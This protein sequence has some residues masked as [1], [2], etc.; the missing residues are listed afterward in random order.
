MLT[1]PECRCAVCPDTAKRIRLTDS[2]GLYLEVSHTSK[3]WFWKFYPNGKESRLALGAYPAVGLK[4]A[5]LERDAARLKWRTEFINP[6]LERRAKRLAGKISSQNTFEEVARE[7]H[8]MRRV[9]W[10]ATY[11]ARWI[12]RMERDMF[13]WIGRM[14]LDFITAPVLLGALNKV[15]KRG[16]IETAHSL[17]Q[18]CGQ[19]FRYGVATGRCQ[20]N[21][22]ADLVD[23]LPPLYVKSVSAI[24]QPEAAGQL[25]CDID[26]YPGQ[27]TTRVCMQ[28]SALLWQRPGN[29]R[30]MRWED[31]NLAEAIWA[32][33]S[34]DMKRT[35]A[36]KLRG[37][38]HYV[39]LPRQ[40]IALLEEV[41]PLTGRGIYVC[42]AMTDKTKPLSE[43]TVRVALRR[44]GYTNEE[45]TPH[46]FRAMARTLLVERLGFA[47]GVVEAQLAHAKSG[48]LGAAYDRAEY[49]AQRREMMQRWADYLDQLRMLPPQSGERS[50]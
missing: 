10:S 36:G 6:A 21:I 26:A 13:P 27:L 50:R 22:V 33:P 42:P 28:L 31:L 16:T 41:R 35:V 15:V 46:G 25:L 5:R 43:N 34:E 49:M 18:W 29:M 8:A 14:P 38:P 4:Q 19:V 32:I 2:G 20:R 24:L 3:R 11:A 1:D 44:M 45:H 9:G 39:P 40:A 17:R 30:A 47:D 37:H 48:P 7:V 12:N 23:V